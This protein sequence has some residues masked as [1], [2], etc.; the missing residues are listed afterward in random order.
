MNTAWCHGRI[1]F[2]GLRRSADGVPLRWSGS[3][4]RLPLGPWRRDGD[5]DSEHRFAWP[6]VDGDRATVALH[7]DAP[8]DVEAQAC[9]LA[10]V[11]GRVK[12]LERAGRHLRRHA[13]AG[14]DSRSVP[15]P[16][17]ASMALSMRLVHTWF[18][19]P[20]YAWIRGTSAL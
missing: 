20:G 5:A 10:D 19:S 8:C 6:G 4:G 3:A 12:G 7:D 1:R 18:S 17:M 13:R 11:L 2:S 9:A 16:A 14:V 15:A